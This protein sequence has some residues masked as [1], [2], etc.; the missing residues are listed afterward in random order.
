MYRILAWAPI[1]PARVQVPRKK[2][3]AVVTTNNVVPFWPVTLEEEE[4]NRFST[5]VFSAN[6]ENLKNVQL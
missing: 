4:E 2:S 1:R 5:F 3:H 6:H